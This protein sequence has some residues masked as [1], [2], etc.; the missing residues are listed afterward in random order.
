MLQEWE[1]F[2]QGAGEDGVV[3]FSMGSYMDATGIDEQIAGLFA[4]AFAQLSQKV[5]WKLNGKPSSKLSPNVKLVDWIPQ[6]D[7]LGKF[8][9][10]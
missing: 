9:P 6:N 7:L 8:F 10:Q 2:L 1:E 3:L 4:G 5:I